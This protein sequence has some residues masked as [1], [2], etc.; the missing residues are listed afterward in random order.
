M[1]KLM[2]SAMAL[3]AIFALEMNQPVVAMHGVGGHGGGVAHPP[4]TAPHTQ[5]EAPH[6]QGGEHHHHHRGYGYGG[7][8]VIII[9]GNSDGTFDE[10]NIDENNYGDEDQQDDVFPD[11]Q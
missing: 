2:T 7:E 6:N 11:N 3:G 5:I 8:G 1:K 10:N 4:T 9:D